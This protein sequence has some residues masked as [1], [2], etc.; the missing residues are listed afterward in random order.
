MFMLTSI[1]LR[2]VY[3]LQVDLLGG[4]FVAGASQ[5]SVEAAFSFLTSAIIGVQV[6][7][8]L[9]KGKTLNRPLA[10]PVEMR[11]SPQELRPRVNYAHVFM[12]N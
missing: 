9:E 4:I 8:E 5:I 1:K 12:P 10:C 6:L 2:Q 7:V 11:D 3:S